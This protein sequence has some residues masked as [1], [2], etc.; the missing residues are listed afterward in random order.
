M[1]QGAKRERGE[2]AVVVVISLMIFLVKERVVFDGCEK[3]QQR[4]KG[5]MCLSPLEALSSFAVL[6]P[7]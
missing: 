4:E 2:Q 5:E 3:E 1:L 6:L 7:P